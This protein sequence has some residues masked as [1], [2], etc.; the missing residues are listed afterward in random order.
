MSQL[1]PKIFSS[2]KKGEKAI[3]TC[4]GDELHELGIRMVADL[5]ELKGWD[6][7]HLGSNTPPA[8]ILKILEEKEIDLLAISATL[9]DQLEGSRELIKVVQANDKLTKVKIMVGLARVVISGKKLGQ[10]VLLRMLKRQ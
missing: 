2:F 4:I 7:I 6:T 5:L 3:T 1:Y 9:P 10:M 8:E